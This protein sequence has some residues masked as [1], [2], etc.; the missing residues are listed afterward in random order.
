M[1]DFFQNVAP[2]KLKTSERLI[3]TD[4]QNNTANYKFTFS[5]EIVPVCKVS[6]FMAPP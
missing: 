1:V 6:P 4:I 5:V 3:S 2:I